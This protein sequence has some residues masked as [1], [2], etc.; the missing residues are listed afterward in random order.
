MAGSLSGLKTKMSKNTN[1]FYMK[2]TCHSLHLCASYSCKKLPSDVEKLCR[3]IYSYFAWSSKRVLELK[4]FQDFCDIKPHKILGLAM[5]RW[6]SLEKVICRIVE[7]WDALQLYFL[8]QCSEVN[9]IKPKESANIML[10]PEIKAYT[11]FLTNALK[12]INEL[13][14][15]FQSESVRLP[16]LYNR[17]EVSVKLI[18]CNFCQTPYIKNKNIKDIVLK[19]KNHFL[20][21]ANIC[22]GTK[23]QQYIDSENLSEF[24]K[25]KIKETIREFYI[26]LISQIKMRFDF[27]R[28]DLK[29]LEA[30]TPA[31]FL[32]EDEL[33]IVPL[34]KTFENLYNGDPDDLISQWNQLRLSLNEG[35]EKDICKFFGLDEP[36][37]K[38]LIEF[39]YNL[40]SLPHSFAAAERNFF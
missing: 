11:L 40:M 6:L 5:T 32:S 39:I 29:L 26:E 25:C 28:E 24:E 9:N 7:Q 18:L 8:S 2:C 34:M 27:E 17:L 1:L 20:P 19:D 13:N 15:E 4:E 37:F 16:Y 22:I 31:K 21:V 23:A 10:V 38:S 3:N 12:I 36:L 14:T 30:I 33:S 35:K